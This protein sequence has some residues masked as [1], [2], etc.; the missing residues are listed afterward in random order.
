M[1]YQTSPTALPSPRAD[2]QALKS[3]ATKLTPVRSSRVAQVDRRVLRKFVL[4]TSAS[5]LPPDTYTVSQ[6]AHTFQG[7]WNVPT[8]PWHP[9]LTNPALLSPLLPG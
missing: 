5:N 2:L 3:P 7:A 1:L 8:F 6:H 9:P 4:V